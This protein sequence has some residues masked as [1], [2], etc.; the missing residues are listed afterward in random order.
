MDVRMQL[1]LECSKP[2]DA[3]VQTGSFAC[4]FHKRSVY[5]A[6]NWDGK[7]PV[8]LACYLLVYH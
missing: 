6:F 4:V 8:D 3:K 2:L 7:Q 1:S 5:S